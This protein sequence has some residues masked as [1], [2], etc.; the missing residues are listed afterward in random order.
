[1]QVEEALEHPYLASLHDVSDEPVCT[2]PFDFD[3]DGEHITPDVVRE[4][5]IR[6]MMGMN[7]D[8]MNDELVPHAVAPV[9]VGGPMAMQL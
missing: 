8:L 9:V 1:M 7:P 4:I 2:Q 6:D 5:I 3:F